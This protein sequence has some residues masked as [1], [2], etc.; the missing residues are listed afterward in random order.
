MPYITQEERE[1]LNTEGLE[2]FQCG[3]PG[4]LNYAITLLCHNYLE[5]RGVRYNT[6]NEVIGILECAKL[7]LYRMIAAPYEDKKRNDNG[8][9]SDL[10]EGDIK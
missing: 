8:S 5:D 1:R 10:D 7:E 4:Q 6:I 9:I 2:H 3:T